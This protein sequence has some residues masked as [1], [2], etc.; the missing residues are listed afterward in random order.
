MTTTRRSNFAAGLRTTILLATLTG[1]LVVHRLRDRRRRSTA[2]PFLVIARG[3]QLRRVLVQRQD[4]P[5]DGGRAS[6]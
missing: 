4:R 3:D 1:L 6:R 5:A 2:L